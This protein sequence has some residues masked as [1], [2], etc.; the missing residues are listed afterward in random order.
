MEKDSLIKSKV[1]HVGVFNFKDLYTVLY[2]W[3]VD[4]SYDMNEKAYKE[5]IGPGG[6]KDIEIEWDAVKKV[7]DYFK[8]N[9]NVKWKVIGMTSV[10]VEIDGVKQKMNKGDLTLEIKTTL[11]KD[12]ESRWE[13]K[14]FWPF[15][16]C[17]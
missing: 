9:I 10:E 17:D 14:P 5:T 4:E 2:E 12:Y 7:S 1:R 16:A 3:L 13:S 11:L 8:F 6:G 15:S